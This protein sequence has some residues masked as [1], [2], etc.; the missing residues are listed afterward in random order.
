M[1]R[2]ALC[3]GLAALFGVSASS[4]ERHAHPP[5]DRLLSTPERWDGAELR[6]TAVVRSVHP[7]LFAVEV[8]GLPLWVRGE[9]AA[10]PG[11]DVE[12]QG[13][14]RARARRLD[15]TS[16]RGVAWTPIPALALAWALWN[17]CRY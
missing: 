12:L 4:R 10:K 17:L 16:G 11:E 9:I 13:I 6:M 1:L 15:L 3:L 8:D 7:G 5:L 14:F 2:L